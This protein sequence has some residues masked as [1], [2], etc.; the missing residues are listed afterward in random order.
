MVWTI[1]DESDEAILREIMQQTD[2][3]AALIAVAYLEERLTDAIKA[4]LIRDEK[5]EGRFFK[6]AG[7][8]ASFSA[9]IDLGFMLGIYENDIQRILHT[10][11]RIRNEF[12]HRTEPLDFSAQRIRGLCLKVDISVQTEL[13][14]KAPDGTVNHVDFNVQSDG[15]PKRAFFNAVKF[16]LLVLDMEIK[17]APPRVPAPPVFQSLAKLFASKEKS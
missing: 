17:I 5:L 1:Q 9:K 3:G 8:L 10:L 6:G 14:F 11:R 12:A 7:P 16:L 13:D 2:R 15:T 4:R